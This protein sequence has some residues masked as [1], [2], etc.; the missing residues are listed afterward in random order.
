MKSINIKGTRRFKFQIEKRSYVYLSK[1]VQGVTKEKKRLY[2]IKMNANNHLFWLIAVAIFY[3]LHS[4]SNFQG[5]C[6]MSEHL[7]TMHYLLI[8]IDFANDVNGT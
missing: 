5:V 1:Y 8:L 4:R 3:T 7:L 6:T 2:D